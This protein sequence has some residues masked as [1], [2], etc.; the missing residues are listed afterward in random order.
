ML[1]DTK[2][3][4]FRSDSLDP[5]Q[6]IDQDAMTQTI[7][8]NPTAPTIPPTTINPK[9]TA[10]PPTIPVAPPMKLAGAGRHRCRSAHIGQVSDTRRL[11]AYMPGTGYCR[12]LLRGLRVYRSSQLAYRRRLDCRSTHALRLSPTG[13]SARNARTTIV[14][15]LDATLDFKGERKLHVHS[16]SLAQ[17]CIFIGVL[18]HL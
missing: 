4:L 9:L 8:Q 7:H 11:A 5:H 1:I 17:T 10:A 13:E 18:R 6:G 15:S 14:A 16:K 12:S 2:F 3:G